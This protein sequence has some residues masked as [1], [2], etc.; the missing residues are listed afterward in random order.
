LS[1]ALAIDA[2]LGDPQFAAWIVA[3]P[4]T[5]WINPSVDLGD[6]TWT[7]GLFRNGPN[8]ELDLFGAVTIDAAAAIVHRRFDP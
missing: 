4:E 8:G 3:V 5:S 6:G 1:P 7:I 2:A